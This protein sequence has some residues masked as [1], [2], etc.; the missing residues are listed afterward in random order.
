MET[1]R[2]ALAA[3]EELLLLGVTG[4]TAYGLATEKSDVDRLGIYCVPTERLFGLNFQMAKASRV[5]TDPDDVQLHEIGKYVG[6]VLKG[7]PTVT[8]LL[9]LPEHEVCDPRV[10]PLLAIRAKLLGQRTVRAA[11]TGY[12]IAQA[13]RL[14]NRKS[15]G[16]EG[17]N[18]DLARRT[19]KH[20]R[21]CFRLML[22][23][24]QLL[25]EGTITVDVSDHRDEL[26]AIGELAERDVDAFL[27]RFEQR[28]AELDRLESPLPQ[29]PDVEAAEAFLRTF[30]LNNLDRR[31]GP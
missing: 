11:Y 27:E 28:K 22:Q 20:G 16:R 25:T 2:A 26:F 4:S 23:A 9:F 6:L 29:E 7:N 10:E 8:E 30:R 5:V 19:A 31:T 21:H 18:S 13:Q 1:A 15:E 3:D 12:A 24:E 17:F 14:A